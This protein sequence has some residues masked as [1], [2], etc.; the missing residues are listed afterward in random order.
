M[1]YDIL[2]SVSI[3]A[4]L[5]FFVVSRW[6]SAGEVLWFEG[7]LLSKRAFCVGSMCVLFLSMGDGMVACLCLRKYSAH[8]PEIF[9]Q[10]LLRQ[11]IFK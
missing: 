7:F 1:T 6:Q 3:F 10:H 5:Q 2:Q 8:I 9:F 4:V 11:S